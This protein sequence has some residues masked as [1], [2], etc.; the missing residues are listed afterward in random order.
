MEGSQWF[1]M[2]YYKFNFYNVALYLRLFRE[3]GDEMESDRIHNQ[4]E[5]IKDF[6]KKQSNIIVNFCLDIAAPAAG[7]W[8]PISIRIYPKDRI[9][10]HFYAPSLPAVYEKYKERGG[11]S[12]FHP[13]DIKPFAYCD[14]LLL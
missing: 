6:L 11:H 14:I 12:V 3:D 10:C 7:D 9:L 4:R 1:F 5:L 8:L 2:S 13:E